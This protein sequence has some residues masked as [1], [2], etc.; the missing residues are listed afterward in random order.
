MLTF[1]SL[2]AVAAAVAATAVVAVYWKRG[3]SYVTA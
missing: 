3:Y 2:L 1:R